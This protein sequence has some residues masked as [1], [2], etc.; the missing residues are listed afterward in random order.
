MVYSFSSTISHSI[1]LPVL[2]DVRQETIK[3][4]NGYT[5]TFLSMIYRRQETKGRYNSTKPQQHNKTKSN[6]NI[7]ASSTPTVTRRL[8]I[9][10]NRKLT[11][12]QLHRIIN[13]APRQQLQ[14]GFVHS[15]QRFPGTVTSLFR[16]E[17]GVFLCVDLG[18][19]LQ[20]HHVLEAVAAA[21]GYGDA[22]VVIG[23][24][25]LSG[26]GRG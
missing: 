1:G 26:G 5:I 9:I 16:F 3:Q 24:F 15:N 22:E 8:R 6:I 11:P 20:G 7:K 4:C 12:N 21:A 17:Y 18:D 14:R 25:F 10:H 19:R 2:F 13:C 23:V